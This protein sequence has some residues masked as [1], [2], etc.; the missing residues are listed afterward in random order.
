M[1]AE[2]GTTA[3]G[4]MYPFYRMT[5]VEERNG[6]LVYYNDYD[7]EVWRTPAP[8]D[9]SPYRFA[10]EQYNVASKD[11]LNEQQKLLW[12]SSNVGISVILLPSI[13]AEAYAEEVARG[14]PLAT[15]SVAEGETMAVATL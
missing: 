13:F 9:Y 12:H 7:Q 6:D 4:S 15:E 5:V 3:S 8:V 11:A 14:V 1:Y 10:I 2:M